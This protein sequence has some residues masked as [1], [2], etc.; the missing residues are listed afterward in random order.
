MIT[1]NESDY[2]KNEGLVAAPALFGADESGS[3]ATPTCVP[4]RENRRQIE[5]NFIRQQTPPSARSRELRAEESKLRVETQHRNRA[6]A[7]IKSRQHDFGGE[8]NMGT[9]D[10]EEKS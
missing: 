1:N 5:R 2:K 6:A 9:A 8:T 3:R 10:E 7:G 4:T